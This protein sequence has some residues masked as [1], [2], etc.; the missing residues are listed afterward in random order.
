MDAKQ[1]I[2]KYLTLF[3]PDDQIFVNKYLVF[4]QQYYTFLEL[5]S[6]IILEQWN[7]IKNNFWINHRKY[8][9]VVVTIYDVLKLEWT[10]NIQT[11]DNYSKLRLWGLV[12][13]IFGYFFSE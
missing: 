9:L 10:N 5:L 6:S 7:S 11:K 8:N 12:I 3:L 13:S 2:E 4:F 1:F